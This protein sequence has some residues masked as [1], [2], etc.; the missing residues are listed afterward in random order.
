MPSPRRPINR[1]QARAIFGDHRAI[2]AYEKID[3]VSSETIAV[4]DG[5]VAAHEAKAN[6]HPQ[7]LRGDS[8]HSIISQHNGF[9]PG[10]T[11]FLRQDGTWA[12]PAVVG[13]G[14]T[15]FHNQPAPLAAWTVNHNFGRFALCE[16]FSVGGV[17]LGAE[18]VNV[19]VNQSQVLF[20]FPL[21]GF[22][23]CS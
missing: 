6:P 18:I 21:A 3:Q 1:D 17:K 5:S 7:Y 15:Y 23:V 2:K 4:I 11:G 13:G 12:A 16:A 14:A 19:S 9:T 8:Q 10:G 22:A 20:V